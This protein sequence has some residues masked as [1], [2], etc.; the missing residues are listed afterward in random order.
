MQVRIEPMQLF[1]RQPEM[2]VLDWQVTNENIFY[3]N[4]LEFSLMVLKTLHLKQ[5][6]FNDIFDFINEQGLSVSGL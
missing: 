1:I 3:K 4:Q 5:E 6:Q 2:S